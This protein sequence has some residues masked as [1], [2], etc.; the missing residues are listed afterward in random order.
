MEAQEKSKLL[1]LTPE[2][3]AEIEAIFNNKKLLEYMEEC[4]GEP[5]LED[6]NEPTAEERMKRIDCALEAL[7]KS[8]LW[9]G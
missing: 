4:D 1:D 9:V 2:Q 5:S 8:K 6:Y 3:E 7:S